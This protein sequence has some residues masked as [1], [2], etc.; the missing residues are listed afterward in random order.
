MRNELFT[1]TRKTLN[2]L[3]NN[4]LFVIP[5]YQR[6]YSWGYDEI[7]K[8]LN[9]LQEN[10]KES[11][12]FIGNIITILNEGKF[13]L[14]D[15]QQ[16]FT[17]L[18]MISLYLSKK[19][20]SNDLFKFCSLDGK[21]RLSFAIR[22]K[23]N[24]YL[25]KL[26]TSEENAGESE[27]FWDLQDSILVNDSQN[28]SLVQNQIIATNF[29][30]ID[31]WFHEN[32]IDDSFLK[33]IKSNLTFEFLIAPE[34][35]DENNLFI[36]INT[37]GT[38]LQHYDIL[39]SELLNAV[40]EDKRHEYSNK[41]ENCSAIFDCKSYS[42][43][44]LSFTK[45]KLLDV[46][47]SN[48]SKPFF[49]WKSTNVNIDSAGNYQQI[50]SFSTLLIHTLFIFIKNNRDELEISLPKIFNTDKLLQ[51]FGEFRNDIIGVDKY[52]RNKAAKD[53]IDCLTKVKE[54]LNSSIIFSDLQ[55]YD[56]GLLNNLKNKEQENK[57]FYKSIEQLQRMLYHS[58]NDTT[59]YWLGIY[60]DLLLNLQRTND[61]D[62]LE[63]LDNIISLKGNTFNT[64]KSY[65]KNSTS[66]INQTNVF[67]LADYDFTY[68]RFNRY[69]FYKLEYV[70]SKKYE[71][72][73]SKIVSRTSVEHVLPQIQKEKYSENN[74]DI[75]K[76]QNLILITVSENSGFSDKN[77]VEKN[78]YRKRLI[79]PPLKMTKLFTDLDQNELIKESYDEISF[80]KLKQTLKDHEDEML[81]LLAQHYNLK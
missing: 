57:E 39:K 19:H 74:I 3:T 66:F 34:G 35:T 31:Q 67:N 30:T 63:K 44:K 58:N 59:H 64:Y 43:L 46:L 72:D 81:L 29:K 40:E 4:E 28:P 54:Q 18:W 33:F 50:I 21:S 73:Q 48:E 78:E 51:V 49:K 71:N 10:T 27:N 56:F 14:V 6:P 7:T 62:I 16:R 76:I 53:F 75:D 70:L 80:F 1:I 22:D 9:D 36:Q 17:T 37:N 79:N 77:I 25:D 15:G 45:E 61:I 52:Q 42:D 65:F 8:L 12:Y 32:I 2:D 11:I 26:L 69:W 47:D 24:E 23:T 38:Q 68:R 41:W 5:A 60:L 13:D 20:E 55:N